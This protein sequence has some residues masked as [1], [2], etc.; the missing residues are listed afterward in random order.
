[1]ICALKYIRNVAIFLHAQNPFAE[2]R[3]RDYE[4]FMRHVPD[5]INL[6]V[7]LL[8][9]HVFRPLDSDDLYVVHMHD[10]VMGDYPVFV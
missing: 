1:M 8:N 5:W 9:Y 2:N 3:E 6:I 4:D 10:D 7:N